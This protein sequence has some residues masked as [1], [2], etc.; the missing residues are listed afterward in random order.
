MTRRGG[1]R[2]PAV[3]AEPR[4]IGTAAARNPLAREVK[5]L[6]ALLGQVL[7]EQEGSDLLEL[8]ERI[9]RRTIALRRADDPTARVALAAELASLPQ[10]VEESVIRAFG[11]YFQL[12]NLAEERHRV[13]TLGRRERA[14]RGLPIEDSVGEAVLRIAR[15]RRGRDEAA[16]LF[17]RIR[18]SPV[19]TAHPTE[20]RRRTL[21]VALRRCARLLAR[22]D[23]PRLTPD[24]DR[25]LRR[26][27]REEIT[28]LW[29][30]A[31]L[32]TIHPT[33][34]DEVRSAMVFFDE[35]LFSVVPA[36]YRSADAALDRLGPP[37]G[38]G[39]ARSA[40]DAGRTGT[41]APLVPA[42]LRLGSWVGGDRDGNAAVTADVTVQTL[43]IQ[44]DHVMRGYE[45][46]ASRL[47]QTI[48]VDAGDEPSSGGL[49]NRLAR[50]ENELPDTTRMLSRRFPREPYRRR[51]GGIA[52]RLRRTR[53]H[54]TDGEG[55]TGGRY[56]DAAALEAELAELSDAL[57]ADGLGRV[58]HGEV[59]D[60][61]WQLATFGFHL[62]SLEIRQHAD[63]HD[64]AIRLLAEPRPDPRR[65]LR[66]APHVTVGE[67]LATMRAVA[68]VQGRFGEE[69]CRRYV[70]SFTRR[71]RD[72]LN[73][74]ALAEAAGRSDIAAS[75]TAGQ[76]P[77]IPTL[78][79][80]PLLESADALADPG[81]L[82]AGLLSDPVYRAHLRKRGDRQEVMLGYSDSNKESGFLAAAWMLYRAQAALTSVARAEGI[83]LTLFHGRGGAIGRGGGPAG[84]AILGQAPGSV[85][86]RLKLTEQGE[87]IAARYADPIVARRELEQMTA[88]TLLASSPDHEAA[89]SAAERAGGDV[90]DE[91]ADRAQIAYRALVWDDPAFEEF[92]RAA[93]PIGELVG[94]RFGSRPTARPRHADGSDA[95][96]SVEHVRA[97]PWVFAWAQSRIALPGW[98]GL[99]TALSGYRAAHGE[100]GFAELRRLYRDWPFFESVIDNAEL[101][102][103]RMDI[104]TGQLYAELAAGEHGRR[105]WTR[106]GD[107]HRLAVAGLLDVTG[108]EHLLDG[109]PALAR[110]IEL[111][112]PYIDALSLAQVG[113][114]GRLRTHRADAPERE[115]D[116][117][118]VGLTVSG[119]AAALQGTG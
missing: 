36:L 94:L 35:T 55:P 60:L 79:V 71:P 103:A 33:P 92:F 72:V 99:G 89:V 21:L 16:R 47:M 112:D 34:L 2:N 3:R 59:A 43:S 67:V 23:D 4:G 93:T 81:G 42:F 13:R 108:R 38:T 25:D 61:R 76:P 58:A 30:T 84:R 96:V 62:A 82:L 1:G 104:G 75:L 44:A 20:A 5:L 73:V 69:A 14:A 22:L 77:A 119:V 117:R 48:A 107:E 45:A 118:L 8:V 50:D 66:A 27:L 53:T 51:L 95:A 91:I 29:R 10:G 88:A 57:V 68:V 17:E 19:L 31:D 78:D 15:G 12:V 63:V 111:R 49:A 46:V 105:I 114:L 28:I 41:R 86:L 98:Y 116:L 90:M 83:E 32:R 37:T 97:I 26:R 11:L 70:V 24:E 85:G 102:L 6:G 109:L 106:I 80:V 115:R 101:V 100:A 40:S 74:L 87:V 52:E 9:R 110:S 7:A 18:V 64:E 65:D 113:L 56:A 39:T 54:L